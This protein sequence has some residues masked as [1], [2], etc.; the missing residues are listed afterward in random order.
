MIKYSHQSPKLHNISDEFNSE[1][2]VIRCP[3]KV[4]QIASNTKDFKMMAVIL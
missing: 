3:F 2:T 1:S 4:T